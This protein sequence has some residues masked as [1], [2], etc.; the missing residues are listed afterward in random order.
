MSVIE[1]TQSKLY[2]HWFAG[3]HLALVYG[4]DI[5][6]SRITTIISRSSAV[7]MSML[8]DWWGWALWS[9]P[10]ADKHAKLAQFQDTYHHLRGKFGLVCGL[11][12]LR[13]ESA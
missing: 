11:L 13:E 4:L 8:N 7:P 5:A 10:F 12:G 1:S 9:V 2:A 3:S 6:W